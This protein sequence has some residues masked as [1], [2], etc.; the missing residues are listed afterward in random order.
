MT[1]PATEI[2]DPLAERYCELL[3]VLQEVDLDSLNRKIT[4]LI[5][6]RDAVT[7][8]RSNSGVESPPSEE[9]TIL[10]AGGGMR[11]YG[12]EHWVDQIGKVLATGPKT[13]AEIRKSLNNGISRAYIS[14]LLK[15][16][17][18]TFGKTPDTF[19]VEWYL[20]EPENTI[21]STP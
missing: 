1:A 13:Q 21:R 14:V 9:A 7:R 11:H 10:P 5:R 3:E 19:P 17:Y 15:K 8:L 16:Y 12:E 6:L 4:R 20:C 2:T 18:D